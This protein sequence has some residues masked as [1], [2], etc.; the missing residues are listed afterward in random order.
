MQCQ[1]TEGIRQPPPKQWASCTGWCLRETSP[2]HRESL[3]EG[4]CSKASF[5]TWI[6]AEME[7]IFNHIL[8]NER[9]FENL[10][11]LATLNWESTIS[12]HKLQKKRQN[13]HN[14]AAVAANRK[15]QARLAFI[16]CIRKTFDLSRAITALQPQSTAI[17]PC[18]CVQVCPCSTAQLPVNQMDDFNKSSFTPAEYKSHAWG[19]A[20]P[21]AESHQGWLLDTIFIPDTQS[22]QH[23]SLHGSVLAVVPRLVMGEAFCLCPSGTVL[24]GQSPAILLCTFSSRQKIQHSSV[25]ESLSKQGLGSSCA[26]VHKGD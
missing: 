8:G 19:W 2:H 11:F 12:A 26:G 13:F 7:I 14:L 10:V 4:Y 15:T 6:S 25:M 21:K 22:L 9:M 1:A 20:L 23:S 24:S 17:V 5:Y 3:G 18:K 16:P